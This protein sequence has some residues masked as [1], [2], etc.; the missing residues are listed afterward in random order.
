MGVGFGCSQPSAF[1][2]QLSSEFT[3][4]KGLNPKFEVRNPKQARMTKIQMF[5][6]KGVPVLSDE[7]VVISFKC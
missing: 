7:W 3:R 5:K 2:L 6:T 4:L 1:G